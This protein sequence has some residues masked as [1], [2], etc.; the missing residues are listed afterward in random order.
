MRI[1]GQE[2]LAL[3]FWVGIYAGAFC[4]TQRKREPELRGRPGEIYYAIGVF[5]GQAFIQC[6]KCSLRSF[7]RNDIAQRFCGHCDLFLDDELW[8]HKQR[9]RVGKP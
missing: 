8:G 7:N 6:G 9:E 5:N 1:F 3:L 2:I 4:W